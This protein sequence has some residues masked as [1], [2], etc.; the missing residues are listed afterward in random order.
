MDKE[1]KTELFRLAET[2]VI[3]ATFLVILKWGI[4]TN[5]RLDAL[6]NATAQ[7]TNVVQRIGEVSADAYVPVVTNN[8]E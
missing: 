1:L 5:H 7:Q 4:K 2:L 6:E 3:A 8:V